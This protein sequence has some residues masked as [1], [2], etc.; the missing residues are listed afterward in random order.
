MRKKKTNENENK[1]EKDWSTRAGVC[2]R[3]P[4]L[5]MALHSEPI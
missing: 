1:K 2:P 5:L 3:H 4:K